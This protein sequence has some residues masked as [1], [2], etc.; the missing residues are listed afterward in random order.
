M[1]RYRLAGDWRDSVNETAI[2]GVRDKTCLV[3]RYGGFGDMIMLS[4]VLPALKEAGFRICLNTTESALDIVKFDPHVDEVILQ[5]KDQVPNSELGEYWDWLGSHFERAVNLSESIEGRLLAMGPHRVK[6]DGEYRWAPPRAEFMWSHEKRHAELN[7]NYIEETHEIAGVPFSHGP[8]FYPSKKEITRARRTLRRLRDRGINRV[9]MWALS[10]SSLHKVYAEMDRVIAQIMVRDKRA[11][12]ITVGGEP[13]RLLERG[14]E[15]EPRVVATAGKLTIRDTLA[16]AQQV[17]CV[18]GPETGVLNAVSMDPV[19]KVI[20][21][22]HSSHENLTKHWENT[23]VLTPDVPCHP[24]H[25]LHSSR[26][27]GE[28]SCPLTDDDDR[29][30]VC[31]KAIDAQDVADA[32]LKRDRKVLYA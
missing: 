5:D 2:G 19:R 30:P 18:V 28:Y 6:V 16:L 8:R 29:L 26:W 25:Q 9:V 10:G 20:M 27:F 17:D 32:I 14:W 24:C 3:I 31:T 4:S 12:L 23:H 15:L 22:S 11:A 7:R 21:L 13:E 1:K